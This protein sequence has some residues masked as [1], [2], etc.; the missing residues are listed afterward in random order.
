LYVTWFWALPDDDPLQRDTP[1]EFIGIDSTLVDVMFHT[2]LGVI[3]LF[4]LPFVIRACVN[5]QAHLGR[6]LLFGE[7]V[8]TLQARVDT[9]AASRAAVVDAE[10][11]GLRRLERDLHDGPQ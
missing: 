4:T 1:L 5:A 11:Q 2:T 6:R 7:R 8:S 10:A 3:M 9:L